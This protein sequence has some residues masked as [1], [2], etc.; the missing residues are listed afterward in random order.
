MTDDPLS[1]CP[2]CEGSVQRVVRSVGIVFK[3]SGFYV[4]DN[5]SNGV[6][7]RVQPSSTE[8]EGKPAKQEAKKEAKSESA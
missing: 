4:T 6:S 7:G 5:R 3:G 2:V 8:S 1:T